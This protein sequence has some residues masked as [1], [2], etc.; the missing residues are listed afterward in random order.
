MWVHHANTKWNVALSQPHIYLKV[1]ALI[2]NFDQA[3]AGVLE[4]HKNLV[5]W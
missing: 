1:S 4:V 2:C 3:I 5:N